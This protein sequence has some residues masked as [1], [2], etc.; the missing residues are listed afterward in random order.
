[1]RNSKIVR[2]DPLDNNNSLDA[3]S[4]ALP[5]TESDIRNMPL[6]QGVDPAEAS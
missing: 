5:I 1:M 2:T 6:Q 3:A 4:K